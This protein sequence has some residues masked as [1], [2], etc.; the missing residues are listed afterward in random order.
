MSNLDGKYW[1]STLVHVYLAATTEFSKSHASIV[2][3][4]Y[5]FNKGIN[6]FKKTG[7][8]ATVAELEVNFVGRDVI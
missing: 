2:T 4:Q 6:I 3:P 1:N 7:Y 5:G 8:D